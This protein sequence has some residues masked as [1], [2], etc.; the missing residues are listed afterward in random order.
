MSMKDTLSNFEILRE[1]S[2]VELNNIEL[3]DENACIDE[4]KELL[5]DMD[6]M[7]NPIVYSEEMVNITVPDNGTTDLLVE[8]ESL[9][10][11]M[12][13]HRVH[14][15]FCDEKMALKKLSEHYNVEADRFVVVIESEENHMEVLDSLKLKL[16]KESDPKK[17]NLLKAKMATIK[18]N[19]N[20]L[21]G[22]GIRTIK[23]G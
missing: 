13:Y 21:K 5:E 22:K 9:H 18:N 15:G 17:R 11:L 19:L 2:S 7:D 20:K 12:E 14:A 8:Y 4:V 3:V 10:K 16:Q 1:A 6:T 23:K